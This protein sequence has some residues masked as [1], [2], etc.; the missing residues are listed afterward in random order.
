[1]INVY[2]VDREKGIVDLL[3]KSLS[4]HG[5]DVPGF[6]SPHECLEKLRDET[7]DVLL[8]D[9]RFSPGPQD[10]LD[11][12]RTI[13]SQSYYFPIIAF[14]AYDAYQE[15]LAQMGVPVVHKSFEFIDALVKLIED[16]ISDYRTEFS[17]RQEEKPL[18]QKVSLINNDLLS[19]LETD[20]EQ[21]YVLDPYKFEEGVAELLEKYGFGIEMTGKTWDEGVDFFAVKKDI[22]T[23]LFIVLCK[24]Y[25]RER[26]VRIG[27][28]RELYGIKGHFA[29]TKALMATTSF[30]TKPSRVFEEKHKW[31]IE[32]K[33]YHDL[34]KLL[35]DRPR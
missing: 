27:E 23:N 16:K 21:F 35:K 7:P 22:L 9:I 12:I 8:T 31:E 2:I 15:K 24:R 34:L 33:D 1:M 28:V 11:F 29:A 10:G 18:I 6:Y 26:L 3:S 25:K 14:T 17:W 19:I 5:Y 13:R 30:Y 20:P 32:L 4:D